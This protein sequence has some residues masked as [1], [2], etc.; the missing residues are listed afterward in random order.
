MRI[1]SI[2]S[3]QTHTFLEWFILHIDQGMRDGPTPMTDGPA[4]TEADETPPVRFTILS[5]TYFILIV[6]IMTA[7]ISGIIIDA[8]ADAREQKNTKEEDKRT[9]DFVSSLNSGVFEHFNID[10]ATYVEEEHNKWNYYYLFMR[11]QELP[12]TEYT[13]VEKYIHDCVVK[14]DSRF[15]PVNLSRRLNRAKE[16]KNRARVANAEHD[17]MASAVADG[18]AP[19]DQHA[20]SGAVRL[21][22][23]PASSRGGDDSTALAVRVHPVPHPVPPVPASAPLAPAKRATTA[24]FYRHAQRARFRFDLRCWPRASA[25]PEVLSRIHPK[26]PHGLW[27]PCKQTT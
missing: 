4:Q 11:L 27:A 19:P 1:G 21:Q 14:M 3:S 16:I 25:N 12:V 6:L 24:H 17:G 22:L 10:F 7:V 26:K 23:A 20:A 13:G 5:L 9:V 2:P 15:F 18:S 8:F